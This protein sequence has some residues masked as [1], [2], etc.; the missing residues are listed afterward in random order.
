MVLDEFFDYKPRRR[1]P[2]GV[3]KK[4]EGAWYSH[5]ILELGETR[6]Q[7]LENLKE[8]YPKWLTSWHITYLLN[9]KRKAKGLKNLAFG[10]VSGRLS[11]LLGLDYVVMSNEDIELYDDETMSFCWPERPTWR[12]SQKGIKYLEASK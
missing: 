1:R 7:I 6:E 2:Q 12:I 8:Q 9:N 3:G 11:E 4:G 5:S 10:T